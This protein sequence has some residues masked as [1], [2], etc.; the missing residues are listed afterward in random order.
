NQNPA[1]RPSVSTPAQAP[2][3]SRVEVQSQTRVEPRVPN[4]PNS[5]GVTIPNQIQGYKLKHCR[6]L[7]K[8][9]RQGNYLPEIDAKMLEFKH[10][11]IFSDPVINEVSEETIDLHM[12]ILRPK[13]EEL[14]KQH[15]HLVGKIL[16]AENALRN[17]SKAQT[18]GHFPKGL[19]VGMKIS[20][21]EE[22]ATEQTSLENKI[23]KFNAECVDDVFKAR[24]KYLDFLLKENR[25]FKTNCLKPFA[26]SLSRSDPT[27]SR[28]VYRAVLF[29]LLAIFHGHE[30]QFPL[31]E[32]MKAEKR[33]EKQKKLEDQKE[34]L[35][36]PA[37]PNLRQV[38]R[39]EFQRLSKQDAKASKPKPKPKTKQHNGS[40]DNGTKGKG[41]GRKSPK[42]GKKRRKSKK[43]KAKRPK[44]GRK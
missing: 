43:G 7:L 32:C 4:D 37:A 44:S 28:A 41:P 19:K 15:S 5:L 30:V 16:K 33:R 23:N 2:K 3:R 34:M 20:L 9:A 8:K 24:K 12:T 13:I 18:E 39:E 22:C 11:M 36:D 25:V 35:L 21:P 10:D 1:R 6:N 31:K 38:I 27:D 40:S 42:N 26:S 17:L 29:K 14:K